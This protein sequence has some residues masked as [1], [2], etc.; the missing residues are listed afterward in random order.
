MTR[1]V[2]PFFHKGLPFEFI[3][4]ISKGGTLMKKCFLEGLE[5]HFDILHYQLKNAIKVVGQFFAYITWAK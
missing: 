5:T 2:F 3:L 1:C 4:F